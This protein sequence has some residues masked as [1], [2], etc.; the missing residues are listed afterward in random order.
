MNKYFTDIQ[1]DMHLERYVPI[2]SL[3]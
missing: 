3:L 2:L 1:T